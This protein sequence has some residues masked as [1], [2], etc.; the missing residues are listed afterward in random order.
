MRLL[1]AAIGLDQVYVEALP[2]QHRSELTMVAAAA[3]VS[4]ATLSAGV[5]ALG[6]LATNSL[7]MGLFASL[8]GLALCFNLHRLLLA[9]SALPLDHPP[10]SAQ[11]TASWGAL[12]L[13]LGTAAILSQ[14]LLIVGHAAVDQ[15]TLGRAR[16]IMVALRHQ[17]MTAV[18]TR[19]IRQLETRL[20]G[21]E[22]ELAQL[23]H[24]LATASTDEAR[25]VRRSRRRLRELHHVTTGQMER[26]QAE[27][28]AAVGPVLDS[29]DNHLRR[30]TLMVQRLRI[31][32]AHP[33]WAAAT[34]LVFLVLACAA[35]PLRWRLVGATEAYLR[36]RH[37]HERQ[38]VIDHHRATLRAMR[39]SLSRWGELRV[40]RPVWADAPFNT[41]P[42][43]PLRPT[44]DDP[45]LA[46][47][48]VEELLPLI[49]AG[50][51]ARRRRDR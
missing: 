3:L 38:L 5:G 12:V 25:S 4:A 9:G 11:W 7:G 40:L 36:Q 10:A 48:T 20:Q 43:A 34:S 15:D 23:E 6:I 50:H 21:Q 26:L 24:A 31:A 19:R 32:W 29:Y 22:E 30:S 18:Y 16:D 42:A 28:D 8:V 2:V 1:R 41:R 35:V 33:L 37:H 17:E 45:R 47:R 51:R 13:V 46:T 39:T 44:H 14:P 49:P 27:F